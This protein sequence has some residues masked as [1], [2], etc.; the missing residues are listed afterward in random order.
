[1][2]ERLGLA[3]RHVHVQRHQVGHIHLQPETRQRQLLRS[4]AAGRERR[5]LRLAPL[6]VAGLALGADA[7]PHLCVAAQAVHGGLR[8]AMRPAMHRIIRREALK[9][10]CAFPHDVVARGLPRNQPRGQY[11]GKARCTNSSRK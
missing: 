10:G 4:A 2:E 3:A 7:Q 11:T 1:M 8:H 5:K 6:A 9:E